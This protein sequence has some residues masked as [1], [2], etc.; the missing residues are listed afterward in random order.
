MI[1]VTATALADNTALTLSGTAAETMTGLQGD[2]TATGVSG[3]LNVT[4]VAVASGLSIATG[5][6][7]NTITATALT[8]GQALTLTGSSAATVTLNA[9]NLAAGTDTGNLTVTGGAGANTITTGSGADTITGGAGADTMTG[10]SGADTFIINSLNSSATVSGTTN[11]GTIVGYDVITDFVTATDFLTLA[12]TPAAAANIG[13]TNG[14]NS[15]LTIGG[16]AFNNQVSQHS[17]TNG[18]ITFTLQGGGAGTIASTSDLAAVVN[19]LQRNDLGNAGVTVAFTATIAAVNH[20]YIYEQ[21]ATTPSAANDILV[22]LSGITVANLTTFISG[23]HL[24]PAG[25][26]GE[27]INLA[28]TD[29]IDHVGVVSLTISGV[30]A[31]WMLNAGTNNGGGTWTVHTNDPTSLT[32]TTAAGFTGAMVLNVA[33]SWTNADGITGS[34]VV[35]DNVEA[36][37]PGSPIFAVSS[38]DH[39]TGSSASDLFVFAQPIANDTIHNFNVAADKIDLIGF[40]GVTGMNDLNIANDANGNAVI[41]AGSGETI[42]V[43]GVDAAALGA[44]NLEFNVEPVTI[45][46]GAM[47]V[48]D[49]AILPIGGTIENSGTIALASTGSETNL[50]ILVG[51]ATLQGGGQ[52]TLSDNGHI[53]IFGGAAEATL[54]NVDN[55][56]TGAGQLGAGQMT[57]VNHGTILADGA[58][59]LVIDTGTNLVTNSGTL[60]A[61]GRGGLVI[62]S[63][64]ANSGSLWADGGNINLHGDVSGNGSAM[65]SGAATLEFGAASNQHVIFADGAAG[66]LK[67]DVSSNFTGS[68]S[69]FAAGDK[70]DLRDLLVGEHSGGIGANLTDYLNFTSTN[71][72]ADTAIQVSSHGGG[73]AGVDQTIVLQGVDMITLGADDSHIISSLLA[74]NK[75]MVDA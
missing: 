33:Q 74:A 45:N 71:S 41:T 10:G 17:I 63:A 42:T 39:L 21:V 23:G 14:T 75:L 56:I 3:A 26:A 73:A 25:I 54:I 44:A 34:A 60:E 72:G 35:A 2:L 31:G 15:V 48:S 36:Y 12:G 1:S 43:L 30:P 49:G 40:A 51:N 50:E 32:V 37:A 27:P 53:V 69:G 66:T 64:L 16:T 70:L 47:T 20:T 24:N 11:T 28:L 6:G 18:I 13:L 8:V 46:A 7:S 65:I 9:G 29:P 67:L 38:V 19:Y 59:A 57:L 58:N 4:T 5:S 61:T 62:D 22:D 52:V 55:T 68:V